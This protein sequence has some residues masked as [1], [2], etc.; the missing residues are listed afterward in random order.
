MTGDKVNILYIAWTPSAALEL[1]S[2]MSEHSDDI[3]FTFLPSYNTT[4]WAG[5]SDEFI[6]AA[7]ELFLE[8]QDIIFCDMLSASI[9]DLLNASFFDAQGN[10]ASL[11]DIRSINTPEYFDYVSNGSID[12]PIC[13]Y[14]NSMG[15]DTE[16]EQENA[17]SLLEYL[18]VEYGNK[19]ITDTWS[20]KIKIMYIA[21]TPSEALELA[22]QNN[23]HSDEIEYTYIP[24][25]NTT[26]W[27]G[28]SDELIA[29]SDSG[30]LAEQDIIFCDMLSASIYDP[31]NASFYDAK[32][33][34]TSMVDIRSI[35]TPDY[36]DY[37][38]DGSVDDP[39]CNY[40]NSMGTGTEVE[41]QNAENLL[42]YLAKEY[43]NHPE[44]TD[45]WIT[46]KV[47][48]IAWAPSDALA[49]ASQT[50]PYSQN[51]EYTYIPSYKHNYLGRTK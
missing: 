13:N 36:F 50:N 23:I 44:I 42:T 30:L 2:E 4:T 24:S 48:Y 32:N 29:A 19:E 22:S 40:Y 20:N 27:A 28:P 12:D 14:Y 11:V 51:I 33:I 45:K 49:M 6:E 17:Q 43:G 10:G 25:Y 35:N 21:W 7:D 8:K 46:I 31:L 3:V 18:A 9:Y 34:G 37:V 15:T 41:K 1:A 38:S 47:L 5:P 26:T 16:E 39:I